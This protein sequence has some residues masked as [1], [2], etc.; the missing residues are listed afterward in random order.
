MSTASPTL[1]ALTG[2]AVHTMPQP[3]ALT[4]FPPVKFFG[5]DWCCWSALH[6]PLGLGLCLGRSLS[7]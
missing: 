5:F 7:I 3:L 2:L 4:C 6:V 1:S